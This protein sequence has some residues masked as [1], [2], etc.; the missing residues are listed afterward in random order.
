MTLTGLVRLFHFGSIDGVTSDAEGR[1]L[2]MAEIADATPAR[3]SLNRSLPEEMYTLPQ[4]PLPQM[5]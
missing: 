3:A 5:V 4:A 2:S 1:L